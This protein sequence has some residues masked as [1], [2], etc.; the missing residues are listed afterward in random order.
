MTTGLQRNTGFPGLTS[1]GSVT[2]H[3]SVV[4]VLQRLVAIGWTRANRQFKCIGIAFDG[5]DGYGPGTIPVHWWAFQPDSA[6]VFV[7]VAAFSADPPVIE[8]TGATLPDYDVRAFHVTTVR[9]FQNN[10]GTVKNYV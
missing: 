3:L 2:F 9:P 8:T 4:R 1:N 5:F 6:P 10:V 7:H